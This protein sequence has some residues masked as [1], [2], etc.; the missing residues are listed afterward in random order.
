M[1][2]I[3]LETLKNGDYADVTPLNRNFEALKEAVNSISSSVY[4][5]L[6]LS[7]VIG[8]LYELGTITKDSIVAAINEL[9]IPT[10]VILP[11]AGNLENVPN[12]FFPCNGAN[13]VSRTEYVRLFK[14]IGTLF[15][16]GDGETTYGLPD[17]R[18]V[19]LRGLDSGRGLD[20][21]RV[22]GSYQADAM[23]KIY[24]RMNSVNRSPIDGVFR[25]DYDAF[26]TDTYKNSVHHFSCSFDNSRVA[27]TADENRMKNL[28]VTH[29]IKF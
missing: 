25:A 7:K 2:I 17:C 26:T 16:E 23:Q 28:A 24:G 9:I 3:T 29:I 10:G 18:G 11:Y 14:V 20:P 12:G 5:V 27:R 8:N 6:N 21:N 15:G 19:V 1:G 4:D 22:L 13:N